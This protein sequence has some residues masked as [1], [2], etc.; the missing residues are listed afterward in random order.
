[1]F[2]LRLNEFMSINNVESFAGH[3]NIEPATPAISTR[4][5]GS[6]SAKADGRDILKSMKVT[7]VTR[8]DTIELGKLGRA[9]DVMQ[10]PIR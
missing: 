3:F 9:I 8:A 2:P 10:A 5:C 7:A 1:M 4:R 6:I